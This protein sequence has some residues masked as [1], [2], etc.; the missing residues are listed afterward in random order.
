[1]KQTITIDLDHA[2]KGFGEVEQYTDLL[3]D[4]L[5]DAYKE[6]FIKTDN[7]LSQEMSAFGIDGSEMDRSR[8]YNY[9]MGYMDIGFEAEHAQFVEYGTGINR[10]GISPHPEAREADWIYGAG[11]E[12]GSKADSHGGWIYFNDKES[13]FKYTMGRYPKPAIYNTKKWAKTQ[14]TK[15]I[16]K[17]L[18]KVKVW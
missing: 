18:R 9:E 6:I 1:M 8:F 11:G 3:E 17:H 15:I 7:H 13:K 4:A 16:R 5:E 2:K 14:I 10:G 12:D